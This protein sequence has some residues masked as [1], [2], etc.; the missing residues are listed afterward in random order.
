LVDW[1]RF[2]PRDFEIRRNK[3]Y[4]DRYRLTGATLRGR[5]LKIIFQLKPGSAVR[6]TTGWPY[7]DTEKK[8]GHIA[9]PARNRSVLVAQASDE[10]AWEAAFERGGRDRLPSRFPA[11]WQRAQS[12]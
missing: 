7:E 6:I 1:H 4:R 5:R 12:S 2:T 8:Q 11:N 9:G 3:R 10:S